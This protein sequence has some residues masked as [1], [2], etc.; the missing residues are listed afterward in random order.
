VLVIA[1]AIGSVYFLQL[2]QDQVGEFIY[3]FSLMISILD[4]ACLL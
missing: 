3:I 4:A 2:G 1:A